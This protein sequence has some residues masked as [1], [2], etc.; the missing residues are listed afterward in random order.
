MDASVLAKPE[1]MGAAGPH[2]VQGDALVKT[3][4]KVPKKRRGIQNTL[5]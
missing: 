3:W 1:T 2:G 5:K 4:C